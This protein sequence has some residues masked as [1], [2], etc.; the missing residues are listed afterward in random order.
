VRADGVVV[1]ADLIPEG[2]RRSLSQ[3][4]GGAECEVV[5][6]LLTAVGDGA[7]ERLEAE[8]SPRRAGP[9][10]SVWAGPSGRREPEDVVE[11]IHRYAGAGVDTVVLSP[12]PAEPDLDGVLELAA[13]ARE[14]LRSGGSADR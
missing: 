13:A 5:I 14:R 6:D 1:D 2:V 9:G 3:V 4:A 10:L 12:T 8:C 11:V 7:R